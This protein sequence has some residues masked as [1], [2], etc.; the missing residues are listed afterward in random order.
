M[1]LC[2]LHSIFWGFFVL[3]DISVDVPSI[4]INAWAF[5]ISAELLTLH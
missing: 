1:T 2:F 4:L 5:V 3:P